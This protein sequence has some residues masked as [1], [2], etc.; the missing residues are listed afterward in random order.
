SLTETEMIFIV[1]IMHAMSDMEKRKYIDFFIRFFEVYEK[2]CVLSDNI[3]MYEYIMIIVASE[4][5]NMGEYQLSLEIDKKVL[6]A[7]LQCRRMWE[8]GNILY[9]ILWNESKQNTEN[10]QEIAKE[11]MTEVLRKCIILSH[12]CRQT[13]RE[14]FLKSKLYK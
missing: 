5:G 11:K 6:K 2:K 4:L 8:S 10:G 1:K 7:S 3:I 13:F 12:F 9:D 14:D